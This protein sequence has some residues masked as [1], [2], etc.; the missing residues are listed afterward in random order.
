MGKFEPGKLSF[1]V[2]ERGNHRAEGACGN[3]KSAQFTVFAEDLLLLITSAQ[4]IQVST[5]CR[6]L[7]GHPREKPSTYK[8]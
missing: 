7:G 8:R 4:K 6:G 5:I 3:T 2:C 1:G